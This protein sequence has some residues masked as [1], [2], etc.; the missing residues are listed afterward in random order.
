MQGG[1]SMHIR[2]ADGAAPNIIFPSVA[3][4]EYVTTQGKSR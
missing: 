3:A 1:F 4:G 2:T